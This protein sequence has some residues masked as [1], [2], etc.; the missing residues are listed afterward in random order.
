MAT[1]QCQAELDIAAA[2][3]LHQ[4]LLSAL[5][6][7]EP[8]EIEGQAVRRIHAAVLQLFLGLMNEARSLGLPVRWHNPSSALIESAQLLG[9]ADPL[10]LSEAGSN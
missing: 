1:I 7:G 8:L 3:T 4:Q 5:Q 6:T 9:L 2:S 10:G